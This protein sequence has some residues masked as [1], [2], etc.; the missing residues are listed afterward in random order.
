MSEATKADRPLPVLSSEG[1]GL[2][3]ER[4]ERNC[5]EFPE[6]WRPMNTAPRDCKPVL[7]FDGSK[8]G[9]VFVGHEATFPTR[10]WVTAGSFQISPT[11]WMPLPAGPN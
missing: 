6:G 11:H 4:A 5:P 1:L 3:P 8:N 10:R 7:L 9:G 2:L